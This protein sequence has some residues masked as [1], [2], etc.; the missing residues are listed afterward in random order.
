MSS[1]LVYAARRAHDKGGKS[2][3]VLA[4]ARHLAAGGGGFARF[5]RLAAGQA[6]LSFVR[7]VLRV[8]EEVEGWK[9]YHLRVVAGGL[10]PPKRGQP[11]PCSEELARCVKH[12]GFSVL[13]L[14]DGHKRTPADAETLQDLDAAIDYVD[15]SGT[16]VKL[17]ITGR[18]LTVMPGP[19]GLARCVLDAQARPMLVVV[20]NRFVRRQ[21]ECSDEELLELWT[22]A[23][24]AIEQ[25]HSQEE[26]QDPFL[27]MCIN[28]GS[29]QNISHLHLK[30][31]LSGKRF[32][33]YEA[34]PGYQVLAQARSE[35]R[36][37]RDRTAKRAE[38]RLDAPTPAARGQRRWEG[39][40]GSDHAC[41]TPAAEPVDAPKRRWRKK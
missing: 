41:P 36:A 1:V 25:H 33:P 23:L 12:A 30:V 6:L 38:P 14:T 11:N 31:W 18:D 28:A 7:E 8:V 22:L 17:P 9:D 10:P 35:R 21:S 20:F 26:E 5:A 37:G 27:A 40:S 34:H 24:D 3:L 19:R 4:P 13:V 29:F 39:V 2:C 16:H 32:R 15:A